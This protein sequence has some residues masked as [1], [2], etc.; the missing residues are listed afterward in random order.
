MRQ[1]ATG[2]DLCSDDGTALR[3]AESDP[4]LGTT[5]AERYE[6]LSV[7][8]FGG[9]SV[10]YKAKHKVLGRLVAIKMLHGDL[11][12]DAAS[13]ERF[14]VEAQAA[15]SLSHP[16]VVTVYDFGLTAGGDPFFVMDF[17]AGESL[18][19]R[20]KR[21]GQIAY[22]EAIDIFRQIAD[23]LE[24]AHNKG[25]V[26]RDLKPSNIILSKQPDFTEVVKI[27]DFGLA[28]VRNLNLTSPGEIFGSPIYMS[29]EQCQGKMPDSR[30]DIYAL[31]CVMYESLSGQP[32]F[33]GE[34]VVKI[35]N[36]HV[37]KKPSSLYGLLKNIEIPS[38]LLD[39]V[40]ACLE[41]NPDDRPQYCRE[42]VQLL[43]LLQQSV[44]STLRGQES[45]QGRET[46]KL[47]RVRHRALSKT[48]FALIG[49]LAINLS[50]I[51]YV[52]F[53][54]GPKVYP[55]TV[56]ERLVL[57]HLIESA[58]KYMDEDNYP[59]AERCFLVAKD[60]AS[61]FH[62]NNQTLENILAAFASGYNRWEGHAYN[63]QQI[64]KSIVEIQNERMR[65]DVN[66]ELM[67]LKNL[68]SIENTP[69]GREKQKLEGE[70]RIPEISALVQTL[71]GRGFTRDA[72]RLLVPTTKLGWLVLSEDKSL[73]ELE[74][75]NASTYEMAR[76]SV[77]A[78]T[79][80]VKALK[81]YKK[82][83]NQD[84][85]TYARTLGRLGNL[86]V[87]HGD[88]AAAEAELKEALAIAR[89]KNDIELQILTLR[90]IADLKYQTVKSDEWQTYTKEAE[91]L[92]AMVEAKQGAIK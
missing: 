48:G 54:P 79:H 85:L 60:Y 20:L 13:L 10:V 23:G 17:L 90:S 38:V 53:C 30:S 32:P 62:D 84:P 68:A 74:V 15:S 43:T 3:G 26:H 25:I 71:L 46:I 40:D 37:K 44:H 52:C 33:M 29:P 5:F 57:R 72:K 92:N 12:Q 65:A 82:H 88:Y 80:Y 34:T 41:K 77:E 63:M 7:I 86:D 67:V 81:I 45:T 89:A 1:F 9:M 47:V 22:P 69:V 76:E 18:Q 83:M 6:I 78:R 49:L 55:G 14:K 24:A 8:G 39:L 36:M 4:L 31:G 87:S 73:A 21:K 27:V 91:K 11:K 35:M 66:K 2:V 42:I 58:N 28:K 16:N 19:E 64:N 56:M 70:A 61:R 59:E 50:C 75:L 51:W